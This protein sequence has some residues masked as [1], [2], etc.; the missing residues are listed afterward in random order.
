MLTFDNSTK[1]GP[2]A[3]HVYEPQGNTSYQTF[4]LLTDIKQNVI[5]NQH[6]DPKKYPVLVLGPKSYWEVKPYQSYKHYLEMPN[7]EWPNYENVLSRANVIYR[8]RCNTGETFQ[9]VKEAKVEI[10]I[11]FNCK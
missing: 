3:L 4:T 6:F 1:F 2:L 8:T 5:Q 11:Q 7:K 9:E 10:D